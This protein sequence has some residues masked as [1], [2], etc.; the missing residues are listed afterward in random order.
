ML[1]KRLIDFFLV[2]P[3]I[4]VVGVSR[5]GDQPAN[6]IFK[7]FRDLRY[8]VYPV[9]PFAEEAEGEKCYPD[10][11]SLPLSPS[12]VM[13]AS[14][15]SVS[16]KTIKDCISLNVSV[17]W[18]HKGIG[19]GSYSKKAVDLAKQHGIQIIENG[20]PMMFLGEVDIFHRALRWW[21]G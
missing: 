6:H 4:A 19:E 12:A 14:T 1:Q 3:I 8:A 21:K 5:S 20:C 2:Q 15:P 13:L 7:K 9:N 17:I 18:L 16:L 11:F 10:L